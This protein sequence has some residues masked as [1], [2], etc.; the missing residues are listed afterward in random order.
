MFC[1]GTSQEGNLE[2]NKMFEDIFSSKTK[3][4]V[5]LLTT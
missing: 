3:D 4:K 5:E 1:K 2:S